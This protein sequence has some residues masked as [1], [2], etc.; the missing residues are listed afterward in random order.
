MSVNN[1]EEK[2]L[3]LMDKIIDWGI[4]KGDRTGVGTISLFGESIRYDISNNTI[5]LLT[6][7]EMFYKSFIVETIW[8]LSGSTD[9]K[10]LKDNKVSIWDDWVIPDTARFLPDDDPTG[11]DMLTWLRC[12]HPLKYSKWKEF[13]ARNKIGQPVRKDVS[14]FYEEIETEKPKFKLIS[15][16]IGKGAY[17]TMWRAWEDI[18]I[19]NLDEVQTLLKRGYTNI[20]DL[21][22]GNESIKKDFGFDFKSHLM[23]KKIDQIAEAIDLIKN[24]PDSRRIIVSAWN[25]GRILDAALPPCHSFFQFLVRDLTDFEILELKNEHTG[26][27]PIPTKALTLILHQRS[28]DFAVG[29]P[30]N[31]G[32]YAL[33][34]HMIAH[35]TN[36]VAETFVWNGGDVHLYSDQ[37]YLAEEQ[38]QREPKDS[39]CRVKFKRNI[40]NIDD[41]KVEDIDFVGYN[42]FHERINYPVS[43]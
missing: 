17:G 37:V 34:A 3:K 9:V 6:T 38:L 19:A 21:Y 29:K 14:A 4:V 25:P 31:L 13:K 22:I 43:V 12:K 39:V 33:L 18:R 32:Q 42:D 1:N 35:V 20:Q 16:S 10:F 28:C 36:T 8:F 40:D 27:K 5:P 24:N 41:F 11:Q 30:F 26:D 23:I 2:Y 15:G 7:K